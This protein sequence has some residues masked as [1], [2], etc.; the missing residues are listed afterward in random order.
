MLILYR[1]RP[2][3]GVGGVAGTVA[4][5]GGVA[6]DAR[7]Q[8]V[9]LHL[10]GRVA[11]LRREHRLHES[12]YRAPSLG[13]GIARGRLGESRMMNFALMNEKKMTIF[14]LMNEKLCVKNE[15]LCPKRE[16]VLFQTRNCAF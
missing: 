3:C 14:A 9:H 15:T 2:L 6:R 10:G 12:P 8:H 11:V 4:G 7:V 13:A 16:T 5:S 1:W